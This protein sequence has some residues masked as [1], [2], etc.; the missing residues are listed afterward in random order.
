MMADVK[1]TFL[2]L[3]IALQQDGVKRKWN[4][5]TSEKCAELFCDE[6]A[7]YYLQHGRLT[8]DVPINSCK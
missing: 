3:V 5:V 8:T 6:G 2:F 4:D 7:K 1:L